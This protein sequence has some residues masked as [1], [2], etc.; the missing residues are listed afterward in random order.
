MAA[1]SSPKE[2]T[3][4]LRESLMW[5]GSETPDNIQCALS[6][7]VAKHASTNTVAIICSDSKLSIGDVCWMLEDDEIIKLV[8]SKLAEQKVTIRDVGATFRLLTLIAVSIG[9]KNP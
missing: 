1:D 8:A 9:Q 2:L 7:E 6:L 5:T 3:K 4:K